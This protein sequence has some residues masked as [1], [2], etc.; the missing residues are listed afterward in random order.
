MQI[1]V[2]AANVERRPAAQLP[3]EL[4]PARACQPDVEVLRTKRIEAECPRG[5]DVAETVREDR[6]L[7]LRGAAEHALLDPR[8]ER[9][10][11]LGLEI[12]ITE[13]ERG[14]AE[15]L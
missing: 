4:D 12:E 3:G 10:R 14:R 2:A 11:A 13:E 6:H 7:D 1:R 9:S 5:D 8:V 15:R